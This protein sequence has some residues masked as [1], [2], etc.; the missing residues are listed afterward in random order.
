MPSVLAI[1]ES[2][3]QLLLQ[4]EAK[5]AELEKCKDEEHLD[6]IPPLIERS[7]KID[8]ALQ[9]HKEHILQTLVEVSLALGK[10]RYEEVGQRSQE[11]FIVK[12]TKE[13]GYPRSPQASRRSIAS[14]VCSSRHPE[15]WEHEKCDFDGLCLA[16]LKYSLEHLGKVPKQYIKEIGSFEKFLIEM[17]NL[18][19]TVPS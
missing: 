15:G 17:K 9:D 2:T 3:E 12:E 13:V 14:F 10:D 4:A 11:F 18:L 16:I 19:K 6:A 8:K 1:L 5:I 7:K